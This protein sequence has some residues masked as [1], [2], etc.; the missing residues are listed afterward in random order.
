MFVEWYQHIDKRIVHC[1]YSVVNPAGHL[2]SR[3]NFHTVASQALVHIPSRS[4]LDSEQDSS[5]IRWHVGQSAAVNLSLALMLRPFPCA[6]LLLC[7]HWLGPG[8]PQYWQS[9]AATL[10]R[11]SSERKYTNLNRF[12]LCHPSLNERD[13][14]RALCFRQ[15][16]GPGRDHVKSLAID[17]G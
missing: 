17:R 2:P 14:I 15:C 12:M 10:R 1:H 3:R 13:Q 9:S 4:S 5:T 11:C 8:A 16:A 6:A 7:A